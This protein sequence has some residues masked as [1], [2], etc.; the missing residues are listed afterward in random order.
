M[1]E[2]G[3]GRILIVCAIRL[4][5][6]RFCRLLHGCRR[7][8]D[9]DLI[10]ASGQWR[11]NPVVVF[12]TGVGAENVT[13]RLPQMLQRFPIRL[14]IV[15]GLCGGISDDVV[16]SRAYV[17]RLLRNLTDREAIAQP[18]ANAVELPRCTSL[19]TVPQAITSVADKQKLHEESGASMVDMEAFA[20]ARI[21]QAGGVPWLVLKAVSDDAQT[22]IEPRIARLLQPDGSVKINALFWL[23][24]TH[25][26]LLRDLIELGKSSTGAMDALL[27][28]VRQLLAGQVSAS[29]G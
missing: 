1:I 29:S 22:A 25:P 9:G 8:R 12:L 16:K 7:D 2:P 15:A 17:P 13:S 27:Q 26:S 14:A 20:A 19:V 23:L 6:N 5:F 4:E 18:L 24:L 28:A 3:E 10:W 11:G 21:L